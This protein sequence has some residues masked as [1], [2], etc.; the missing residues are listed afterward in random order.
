MCRRQVFPN[1]RLFCDCNSLPDVLEHLDT[2]ANGV[3]THDAPAQTTITNL[4]Y[5]TA[6]QQVLNGTLS[7]KG[8]LAPM[9][10]QINNP[11]MKELKE[12]YG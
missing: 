8:I 9:T 11:L 4:A 10:P 12:K 5:K 7:E 2:I 1:A 6:V 3:Q